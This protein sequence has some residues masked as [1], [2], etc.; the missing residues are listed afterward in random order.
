[1]NKAVFERIQKRLK[2]KGVHYSVEND[3]IS[4]SMRINDTV[5][6]VNVVYDVLDKGILSYAIFNNHAPQEKRVSIAEY[7]HRA[8]YGL[9]HG[10]FEMDYFD[11][12]IR[13]KLATY[14]D[15]SNTISNNL[16]DRH[17]YIPCLMF[18]RYGEG[19]LKLL[20]GEGDPESLISEAEQKE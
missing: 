12:E 7:L 18:E 2:D 6:V 10:N 8:N 9:P 16:I 4:M 1:M 17:V 3:V 20:V 19:I 11:G 14:F 15:D 13:F 5:G